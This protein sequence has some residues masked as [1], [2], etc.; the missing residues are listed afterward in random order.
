MHAL[1][2]FFTIASPFCSVGERRLHYDV[3]RRAG[4]TQ[5]LSR[6]ASLFPFFFFHL[7]KTTLASQADSH[8]LCFFSLCPPLSMLF[9][10][11]SC[12]AMLKWS[13]CSGKGRPQ[14]LLES[15]SISQCCAFFPN[16]VNHVSSNKWIQ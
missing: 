8:Y 5:S 11:A 4:S 2:D 15:Q 1:L 12:R 10:Q 9:P 14:P 13:C 7:P 16:N 6:Y 3:C